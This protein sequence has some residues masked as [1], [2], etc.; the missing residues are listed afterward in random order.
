MTNLFRRSP[1][2]H[3]FPQIPYKKQ[4]LLFPVPLCHCSVLAMVRRP[5]NARGGWS[6]WTL[7]VWFVEC[8]GTAEFSSRFNTGFLDVNDFSLLFHAGTGGPTKEILDMWIEKGL[9]R[10]FQQLALM[11]LMHGTGCHEKLV[12][13]NLGVFCVRKYLQWVLWKRSA[14]F[15]HHL[16]S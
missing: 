11:F 16:L 3:A 2:C 9:R 13:I 4:Y 1:Y 10:I 12:Q 5:E 8:I 15:A 14:H 6:N 7:L